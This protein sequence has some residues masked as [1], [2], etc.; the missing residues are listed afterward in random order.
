MQNHVFYRCTFCKWNCAVPLIFYR[1]FSEPPSRGVNLGIRRR[2]QIVF[3]FFPFFNIENITST[4]ETKNGNVL[5]IFLIIYNFFKRCPDCPTIW[6]L[7][8][9]LPGRIFYK[10]LIMCRKNDKFY[11]A[12]RFVLG[13]GASPFFLKPSELTPLSLNMKK[14]WTFCR[15]KHFLCYVNVI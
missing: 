13:Q 2:Y 3:G 7:P 5:K 9:F 4:L 10:N 11:D 1:N 15:A 6:L 8:P 12:K 14:T